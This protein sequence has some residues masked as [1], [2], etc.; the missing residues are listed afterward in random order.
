MT[1]KK[2]G[3]C[4]VC[5]LVLGTGA[6]LYARP[7]D[8]A[9]TREPRDE[10]Q[11]DGAPFLAFPVDCDLGEDCAI[12]NYVDVDPTPAA[13]D[14]TGGS[15]SYDG[16][17]GTDIR[18]LSMDEQRAGVSVLA[19][20]AGTVVRSRDGIEDASVR[21]RGREAVANQECGNGVVIDHGDGWET[22]YCH[23]A[24][25]SIAVRPG[26]RVQA[27]A[28]LGDV[29]LSGL[30]EY[31]HLHFTVRKD[32]EV[33]DPFAPK[34]AGLSDRSRNLWS[35]QEVNAYHSREILNA[36]FSGAPPSMEDVVEHGARVAPRP[37]VTSGALVAFV[38]VMGLKAGDIQR[39]VLRS[40]SGQTLAS[41]EAQ[42]LA[43]DQAQSLLFV[44]KKKPADGWQPGRYKAEYRVLSGGKPVLSKSF[45][46]D[47]TG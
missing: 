34:G 30:T 22:Q 44:G 17:N 42:A 4:L 19:A 43:R 13:H 37:A 33:V 25:G 1:V 5:A 20:A 40:P 38:Q 18:L 31:P 23:M 45:E 9:E 8:K 46:F 28:R 3:M 21:R 24:E 47:L 32:G 27:G 14:H 35:A 7:R 16:H 36:G 12:Q 29:G 15:R 26:Q 10:G 2:T 11:K 6:L 39:L 41:N